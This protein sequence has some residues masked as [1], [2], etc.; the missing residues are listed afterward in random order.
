MSKLVVVFHVLLAWHIQE[1]VGKWNVMSACFSW[2]FLRVNVASLSGQVGKQPLKKR[3]GECCFTFGSSGQTAAKKRLQWLHTA[4]K[5]LFSFIPL[6]CYPQKPWFSKLIIF[7][8]FSGSF[9]PWNNQL[10]PR[11]GYDPKA[12]GEVPLPHDWQDPNFNHRGGR[13]AVE[14]TGMGMGKMIE[15]VYDVTRAVGWCWDV[16]GICTIIR[17]LFN[18]HI[19]CIIYI[20]IHSIMIITIIII[21]LLIII[22]I[23]FKLYTCIYIYTHLYAYVDVYVYIYIYI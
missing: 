4:S 2:I 12:L 21:L 3:T 9:E 13:A 5:G 10:S 20:Y 16:F 6:F 1:A 22:I 15:G 17:C 8:G 19:L 11:P 18:I 7:T 14:Q 23:Y